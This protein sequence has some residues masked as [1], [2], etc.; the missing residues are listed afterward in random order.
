LYIYKRNN[1]WII[2]ILWITLVIISLYSVY[3]AINLLE[4][5]DIIARIYHD[6]DF[7]KGINKNFNWHDETIQVLIVNITMRSCSTGLLYLLL[8][9]HLQNIIINSN[10]EFK[11][12]KYLLG[13]RFYYYFIKSLNIASKTNWIWM[14]AVAILLLF[15][16]IFSVWFAYF[17]CNHIYEITELYLNSKK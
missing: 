7:S 2:I 16:S 1:M 17:I 10:K 3:L 11:F 8:I 4:D 14:I 15:S 12:L 6:I 13:E 9:F 5:F